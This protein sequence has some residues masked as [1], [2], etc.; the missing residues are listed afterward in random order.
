MRA[1]HCLVVAALMCGACSSTP[2]SLAT[3]G[4]DPLVPDVCGFPFPSNA[5]LVDD[6]K[7]PTGHHVQFGKKTL[8]PQ[9]NKPTDPTPWTKSDGFSP[10]MTLV[11]LLRGASGTGLAD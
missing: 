11:T 6:A 9:R 3:D 8:P 2:D 4:C 1:S 5:W 10:G 7:T